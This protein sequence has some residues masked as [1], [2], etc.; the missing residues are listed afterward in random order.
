MGPLSR[1]A[2]WGYSPN[3]T[4][5]ES[6]RSPSS[7]KVLTWE[8]HT[9]GAIQ[10][11]SKSKQ[12]EHWVA[13]AVGRCLLQTDADKLVTAWM[14]VSSQMLLWMDE[15]IYSDRVLPS[16]FVCEDE[17]VIAGKTPAQLD[18]ISASLNSPFVLLMQVWHKHSSFTNRAEPF[19]VWWGHPASSDVGIEML[20]PCCLETKRSTALPQL[21]RLPDSSGYL[22]LTW[23]FKKILIIV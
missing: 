9:S 16:V 8:F 6:L 13:A 3:V 10:H 11:I 1:V 18:H 14:S 4:L 20:L 2:Q 15:L 17:G 5:T 7:L 22:Y 19:M 12:P 21:T 23:L